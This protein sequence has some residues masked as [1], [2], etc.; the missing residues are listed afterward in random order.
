VTHD[1]LQALDSTSRSVEQ[2]T[3]RVSSSMVLVVPSQD[4]AG[5]PPRVAA[6][7]AVGVPLT[8]QDFVAVFGSR[9]DNAVDH[10]L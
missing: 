4:R 10:F 2:Q 7:L 6:A 9:L 8:E 5:V 1:P 3:G